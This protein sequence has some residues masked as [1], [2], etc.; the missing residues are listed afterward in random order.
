MATLLLLVAAGCRDG[1]TSN[2]PANNVKSSNGTSTEGRTGGTLYV[3]ML[4][5]FEH[6]DPARNY[7]ASQMDFS[8][9]L[10]RTLTTYKAVPGEEGTEVV[11]D[12]ATNTGTPSDGGR[13]WTF[14]LKAGLKYE[15][16]SAITS[17][18]IKYGV[19]RAFDP[20]L[21]EGPQYIQ[22]ALADVPKGYQGPAKSGGQQLSSIQTPDD[23][24]IVFHL[25]RAIGDF[26]YLAAQP[27]TAPVPPSKDTGTR[28]DSR[29][30]SSGPYKIKNYERDQSMTLVRNTY[31]DRSTDDVRGAYPDVI[32]VD[33]GVDPAVLDQRLIVDSG[34]DKNAIMFDSVVQ[35]PDVTSVVNNPSVRKRSTS[36]YTGATEFLA[37]NTA[38]VTDVRVRQAIAYALNKETIRT[39]EGGK[40]AGDYA[41]TVSNPFIRGHEDLSD[42]YEAPP[43]GDPEKARQ[44]LKEAGKSN[45]TLTLNVSDSAAGVQYGTA[46][47]EALKR[48]G[49]TVRVEHLPRDNY[50]TLVGDTQKAP[51]LMR[52]V[53]AADWPSMSTILPP[54][55]CGCSIEMQGNTNVSQFNVPAIDQQMDQIRGI[56]D[57]QKRA[58]AWGDLEKTIME[59]APVV[60]DLYLKSLLLHGSHVKG[61]Y[62][63]PV[64]GTYDIVSVSVA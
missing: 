9:L 23:R 6:L 15:D 44:L 27:T 31:W 1:G 16:G 52:Y 21:S 32:E 59:Q 2:A 13:T 64:Y 12:L 43:T 39:G 20:A 10:Y 18:D 24:T 35:P 26:A 37:I 57:D 5:D 28:Y 53:W 63:H 40:W 34:N 3:P 50:Y 56:T 61:A 41:S 33:F 42:L 55:F 54:L 38:K 7:I 17:K 60:P 25:A 30:F 48:A 49:I 58:Q 29:V 11:G 45:L 4:S 47:Q 46:V 22:Q 36:G 14:T 19:E 8:R 51:D 62:I